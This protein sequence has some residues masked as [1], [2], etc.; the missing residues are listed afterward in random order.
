MAK[1]IPGFSQTPKEFSK[2]KLNYI[3]VGAVVFSVAAFFLGNIS[4][5]EAL[6]GFSAGS[7]MLAGRDTLAKLEKKNDQ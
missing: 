2:K 7:A 5:N 1:N 3:G 4:F 6:L